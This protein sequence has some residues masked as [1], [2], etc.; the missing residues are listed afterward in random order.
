MHAAVSDRDARPPHPSREA[1]GFAL[2]HTRTTRSGSRGPGRPRVP[3][4]VASRN[5]QVDDSRHPG[6]QRPV[7]SSDH[8]AA[9]RVRV[10]LRALSPT[11]RRTPRTR[12]VPARNRRRRPRGARLPVIGRS[13]FGVPHPLR[14]GAW[15]GGAERRP[16]PR[17][18][19]ALRAPSL[20]RTST[21]AAAS[22]RS[23]S[24][25][26]DPYGRYDAVNYPSIPALVEHARGGFPPR[27]RPPT[28]LRRRSARRLR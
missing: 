18:H 25:P 24:F 2:P 16:A 27:R 22:E 20:P 11:P 12:R 3:G 5:S 9:V 1:P 13:S 14:A 4:R 8:V 23:S 26:N 28:P 19:P 17:A 21:A 10:P 15:R 6:Q 7:A